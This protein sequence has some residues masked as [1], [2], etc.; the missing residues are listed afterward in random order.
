MRIILFG[1]GE[2][3]A[4]SLLALSRCRYEIAG[5]VCRKLA[6][7]ASLEAAAKQLGTTV[8]QPSNVNDSDFVARVRTLA[9]DLAISISYNQILRRAI[10]NSTK[11]GFLNFHAGKLPNYRGRNVI[12][13]AIINGEDE[14]GLTAHLIDEGIDT[15][16]IVLQRTL[17]ISW[18]DTYGDVLERIVASFP[19]FVVEVV[20][21]FCRGELTPQRQSHIPGT[22]FSGRSNGDEWLDWSD[23][24]LNL[25]NKIRAITR[26]APGARTL[27]G[28]EEVVIW[29][30]SYNLSWPKYIA[31]PG[32]IVGRAEE[33]V[34]VKTGDSTLVIKEV[35]IE[36]GECG[37]ASWPIGTRLGM[38]LHSVISSLRSRL[39]ELENGFRQ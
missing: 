26:P 35:Q 8:L 37:N 15:G 7:D 18:T 2:W 14:I 36:G 21:R 38:N 28:C 6:S 31:T 5:V 25:Y 13:W 33:G 34:V 17:P 24:S 22:Y 19:E 32:Q 11:L 9:P 20:E 10:L 39:R 23:S 12:N 1:D 27:V 3:A 16:D 30:A 4:N 29:G